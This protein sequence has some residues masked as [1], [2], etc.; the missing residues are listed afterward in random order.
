MLEVATGAAVKDGG[1]MAD[2]GQRQRGRAT[3]WVA[4]A[5]LLVAGAISAAGL[6]GR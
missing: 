2:S 5:G 6:A 4:A 1:N 3:R